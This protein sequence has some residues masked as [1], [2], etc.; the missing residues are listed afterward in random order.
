[1]TKF[2]NKKLFITIALILILFYLIY[3]IG[4][5]WGKQRHYFN[6]VPESAVLIMEVDQMEKV[7]NKLKKT[8]YWLDL[9][10]VDWIKKMENTF[11]L[12]DSVFLQ[13][14]PA[15]KKKAIASIHLTKADDYDCLLTMHDKVLSKD[16]ARVIKGMKRGGYKIR[17]RTFK[18]TDI[19]ELRLK[20]L[21]RPLTITSH[22]N[23]IA[24]SFSAIL[25]DESVTQGRKGPNWTFRDMAKWRGEKADATLYADCN[26]VGLLAGVFLKDKGNTVF[27]KVQELVDWA[28]LDLY[29]T[30][31]S[32]VVDGHTLFA[33][34]NPI[35]ERLLNQGVGGT[36]VTVDEVLPFNT[37]FLLHS[38][39]ADFNDF[40]RAVDVS[41]DE[42]FRSSFLPWFGN[43]W[44][45]GFTEPNS[46][47]FIN[48]TFIIVATNDAKNA[49]KKLGD[50]AKQKAIK[51]GKYTLYPIDAYPLA[52][53]L[54]DKTTAKTFQKG[55]YTVLDKHV[56]FAPKQTTLKL[57]IDQ[58]K[59]GK[60]LAKERGYISF[61]RHQ[62]KDSNLFVYVQPSKLS[63]LLKDAASSRFAKDLNEKFKY[64]ERVSPIT[65]EFDEF[66]GK[67][68]T[69][70]LATY[71]KSATDKTTL[72]WNV[73]LEA[74][75]LF[76]PQIVKN[77]DNGRKEIIVQDDN[78]NVYLI[79]RDGDILWK[80]QLTEPCL[81]KIYQLDFYGNEEYQY[82]FNTPT[83][84]YLL[85]RKGENEYNFPIRLSAEANA[86]LTMIDVGGRKDYNFF[87]PCNNGNVYGYHYSGRP[88]SGWSP[89]KQLSQV[90]YPLIYFKEKGVE[91]LVA[92]NKNG[93]VYLLNRGGIIKHK[94][95]TNGPLIAPPQ[96]ALR[97]KEKKI[98]ATTEK[99]DTYI[100]DAKGEYFNLRYT[101]INEDSRFLVANTFGSEADENIFLSK[102]KV[103]VFNN[104]EQLYS[105]TFEDGFT[106]T[107]LFA[108]PPI[109]KISHVGVFSKIEQQITLLEKYGK[110]H[111]DF[112]LP[113]STPFVASDLFG[114]GESIIVAGGIDNNVFAYK[115]E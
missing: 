55:F 86:G 112:P 115:V 23:L 20:G 43:E 45:Y 34:D 11:A 103:R 100:I 41:S 93:T 79:S 94:I 36:K 46:A 77:F 68:A 114:G 9:Q 27:S 24:C 17:K 15:A 2:L 85:N 92:A 44:A 81:G 61:A 32:L 72:V 104:K 35:L 87:V 49:A 111:P 40:Y 30:D 71:Q 25:V 107:N 18:D 70:G 73:Q 99:G 57:V 101:S 84:I 53:Q 10:Q 5:F 59:A 12:L 113:A 14:T 42:L 7:R 97:G 90:P 74:P 80:R 31:R 82:L 110:F 22:S 47:D 58:S 98:L 19:Y 89:R 4:F 37:A 51:Y 109:N 76:T 108:S 95:K 88:L 48:G 33:D 96:I 39:V 78:Y 16:L 1:M 69:A 106:P 64:Y 91:S 62:K 63:K 66:K 6:G 13:Q 67:A 50:Y 105:Y 65:L 29:F 52:A 28:Q 3:Y 38:R 21:K 83:K 60:T 56:V 8:S 26:N 75:A 54:Y 102:G